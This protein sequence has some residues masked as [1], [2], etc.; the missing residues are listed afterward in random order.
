MAFEGIYLLRTKLIIDNQPIE[1]VSHFY[2][3]Y[4]NTK[5][6]KF[7]HIQDTGCPHHWDLVYLRDTKSVK[8]RQS[9]RINEPF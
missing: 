4:I 6:H 9:C 1:Q 7:Q 3:L 5:F 2:Y 8:L